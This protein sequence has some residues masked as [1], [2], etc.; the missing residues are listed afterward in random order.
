[1][2]HD[3]LSKIR[4]T[5]EEIKKQF[6][7]DQDLK[8]GHLCSY[9]SLALSL[10]FSCRQFMHCIAQPFPHEIAMFGAE[11]IHVERPAGTFTAHRPH[12]IRGKRNHGC[13]WA[14]EA[15][16]WL[17]FG[18]N[19]KDPNGLELRWLFGKYPMCGWSLCAR[20]TREIWNYT[21]VWPSR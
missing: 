4:G 15:F 12:L 19:F 5:D 18:L 17:Y 21:P 2:A 3:K 14:Y 8:T 9:P 11:V 10:A 16:N 6:Q 7:L 13:D 1:M 20:N